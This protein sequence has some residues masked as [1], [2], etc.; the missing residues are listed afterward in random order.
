MV[1]NT[2]NNNRTTFLLQLKLLKCGNVT[3]VETDRIPGF[4]L[5][6]TQNVAE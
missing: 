3:K 4:V 6:R 2:T 5:G 1:D